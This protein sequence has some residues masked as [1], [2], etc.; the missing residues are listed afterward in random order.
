[1]T[2][3]Y[4]H[5]IFVFFIGVMFFS[6]TKNVLAATTTSVFN[7]AMFSQA[8]PPSRQIDSL[9]N[10]IKSVSEQSDTVDQPAETS[11]KMDVSSE[12]A[13]A[14]REQMPGSQS[15]RKLTKGIY[16]SQT[17]AE[18]TKYFTYL[19]ERSKKVGINTFIVDLELPSKRYAQNIQLLKDNGIH[20]VARNI[21]F[22]GGGTKKQVASIEYREKKLK[23]AKTAIA[24]G[25]SQIQLDYIRYNTKQIP[26]HKNSETIA[27]LI[28]WFKE[29][30]N[31]P[32]QVD[33]FGI[34]SYGES[35]YIGQNIKLIGQTVDVLC[36]MVYPSHYEPYKIHAVTPYETVYNSLKA[37]HGQ[38]NNQQLP[39][40]LVPYI[41]LS[42][43]R[44][45]LSHA[46]KMDYIYSQIQAAE[47][48]NADGWY[49]WS[50]RNMYDNLFYILE[51]KKVR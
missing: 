38:Y 28:A 36:P 5:W 39:F 19:I 35:K 46:K 16:I 1:M 21:V 10:K 13:D 33:V 9:N 15:N 20:Y 43:Y 31:V 44:Y 42:N 29:N 49:V 51:T 48:A 22:P 40:K 47:N 37:I 30:I 7:E 2:I 50:A 27:G 3:R 32:L 14:A 34:S 45:K 25:A 6:L 41:E 26:S 8:E 11:Q 4:R 23:L 18:D 17:T 24:Y 12:K